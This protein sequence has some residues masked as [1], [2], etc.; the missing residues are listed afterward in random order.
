VWAPLTP[1]AANVA[2]G[3][4]NAVTQVSTASSAGPERAVNGTTNG[5]KASAETIAE[6]AAAS[7]AWWEIDLGS[8][9][10]LAAIDV[11][12]RL[13]TC[14]SANLTNFWVFV[15]DVPFDAQ[16]VA[17]TLSQSGVSAWF[18]GAS[19]SPAYRFDVARR[20]RFIRVQLT[21]TAALS[22]PEVQVWTRGTPLGPLARSPGTH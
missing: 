18:Q 12:N 17:G 20:G 8:V 5:A 13:D 4:S 22:L 3:R 16:T 11:W 6:T 21:G 14:C 1:R 9:Q 19:A 2:G 10:P 7:E 15:S